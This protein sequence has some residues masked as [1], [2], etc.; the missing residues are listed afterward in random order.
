M[1]PAEF[2]FMVAQIFLARTLHP[3]T[4]FLFAVFWLGVA[5]YRGW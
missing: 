1:T 4:A 5:I 2:A 3:F